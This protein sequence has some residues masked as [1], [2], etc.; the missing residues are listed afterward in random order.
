[1][2]PAARELHV[3]LD[4]STALY[5]EK[6]SELGEAELNQEWEHVD[7]CEDELAQ[8]ISD[9]MVLADLHGRRR[10][11]I[12]ADKQ[13]EPTEEERHQVIF[14]E[15]PVVPKLS[16]REAVRDLLRR[17]P[18]LTRNYDQVAEAYSKGHVFALAKRARLETVER[19]RDYVAEAGGRGTSEERA[20]AVIARIGDWSASYGRLVYRTNTATAVSAGLFQQMM[21]PDV[22]EVMGAFEY[23]SVRDVD[24]RPNHKAAHGLVAPIN[25]RVWERFSTPMGYN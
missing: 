5:T 21:D 13:P 2:D 11:W 22:A 19:V 3:L 1:M 9:T 24:T 16:F 8:L 7:E 23:Y 10:I 14:R 18:R 17:E 15:Q 25:H 4:R 20:G 6:L 12:E